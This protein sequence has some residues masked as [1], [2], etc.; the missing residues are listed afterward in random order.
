MAR[1]EIFEGKASSAERSGVR[2]PNGE[3]RSRTRLRLRW[4][5]PE[6]RQ[7]RA[8]R[9]R[10]PR[11]HGLAP[12]PARGSWQTRPE[13][14]APREAQ[15]HHGWRGGDA[16]RGS[17][18]AGTVPSFVTWTLGSQPPRSVDSPGEGALVLQRASPV[19]FRGFYSNVCRPGCVTPHPRKA[20]LAHS[21]TSA[22]LLTEHP[23]RAGGGSSDGPGRESVRQC[24]RCSHVTEDEVEAQRGGHTS[25]WRRQGP[26][27]A[28]AGPGLP[29]GFP[30][31][32]ERRCAV[33][34]AEFVSMNFP[35]LGL[36]GGTDRPK[37]GPH[38]RNKHRRRPA[39]SSLA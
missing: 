16:Q 15:R 18:T 17:D 35:A 9:R 19:C 12:P 24:S 31:P 6:Q 5:C 14:T 3:L 38:Q 7:L 27:W 21:P 30:L 25:R 23:P 36:P 39:T 22:Q 13:G 28:T 29:R 26:V 37:D 2:R 20:P 8:G 11:G 32:V 33:L 4:R 1:R 34:K 10:G